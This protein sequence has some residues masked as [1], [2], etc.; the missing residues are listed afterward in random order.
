MSG[1]DAI[2]FQILVFCFKVIYTLVPGAH[3]VAKNPKLSHFDCR[4]MTEN[5]L[6]APNQLRQCHITP[7][8]MEN[9]QTK[10]ILDT[11]HFRKDLNATKCRIQP[12][13]EKRH[14]G[15]NDH[16]RIDPTIAAITSDLVISPEQ[17][18]S[19]A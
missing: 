16:S 5:S 10:I 12:H 9:S 18:R 15:H 17:R 14:S 13:P 11:K 6:Y 8:E 1:D 3:Q 2:V 4:A 19:F 7:E